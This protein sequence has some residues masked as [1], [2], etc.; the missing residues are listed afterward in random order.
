MEDGVYDELLTEAYSGIGVEE[1]KEKK[2]ELPEQISL[3]RMLEVQASG[4]YCEELHT[5]IDLREN[6]TFVLEKDSCLL[7]QKTSTGSQIVIPKKL[8]KHILEMCHNLPISAHP[9]GRKMYAPLREKYYCPFFG[10]RLLRDST[11][12]PRMCK[13]E[14]AHS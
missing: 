5:S 12:L 3:D 13:R 4:E 7:M 14:S 2:E 8:R 10:V 11:K 1:E 6:A 9:G